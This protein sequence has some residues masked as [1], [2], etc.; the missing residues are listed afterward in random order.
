MAKPSSITSISCPIRIRSSP[1]S[2]PVGLVALMAQASCVASIETDYQTDVRLSRQLTVKVP[3]NTRLHSDV[4]R[5]TR[6]IRRGVDNLHHPDRLPLSNHR[7]RSRVLALVERPVF[8]ELDPAAVD[9]VTDRHVD[10][11][12]HGPDGLGVDRS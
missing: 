3:E 11:K 9:A 8:A 6:R 12:G 1:S 5:R 7:R 10:S 2:S 4:D